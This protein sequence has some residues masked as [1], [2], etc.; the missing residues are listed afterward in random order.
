[1]V[2]VSACLA[3]YNCRYNGQAKT[4]PKIAD[5]VRRGEAIAVCPEVLGGFEIPHAPAE[6]S[7]T[8]AQVLDGEARIFDKENNDVT[9][10][11]L[12]GVY[13]VLKICK[14]FNVKQALLKSKSPSCGCGVIY[15]GSFTGKL[16]GGDGVTAALLKRNG[17]QV[18]SI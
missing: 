18:T 14:E 7:G 3:G 6:I 12:D 1:M 5:M 9:Q 16:R 8:G 11:Y 17:I 15:D 13:S 10:K 4:D 2:I